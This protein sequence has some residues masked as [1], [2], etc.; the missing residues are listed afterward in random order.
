[1]ELKLTTKKILVIVI[2]ILVVYYGTF[3]VFTTPIEPVDYHQLS[4]ATIANEVKLIDFKDLLIS[5][6]FQDML[7]ESKGGC[8]RSFCYKIPFNVETQ[9]VLDINLVRKNNNIFVVNSKTYVE[10]ENNISIAPN[11]FLNESILE[12]VPEIYLNG[13]KLELNRKNGFYEVGTLSFSKEKH[14]NVFEIK[15]LVIKRNIYPIDEIKR[16]LFFNKDNYV[17]SINLP[18]MFPILIKNNGKTKEMV[19]NVEV[20]S[21]YRIDKETSGFQKVSYVGI[22]PE[23]VD[24]SPASIIINET[25]VKPFGII[26]FPVRT[27]T[28]EQDIDDESNKNLV[29]F[30]THISREN[31][32]YSFEVSFI[33]FIR[34]LVVIIFILIIPLLIE[35]QNKYTKKIKKKPEFIIASYSIILVFLGGYSIFNFSEVLNFFSKFIYFTSKLFLAILFSFPLIYFLISDIKLKKKITKRING[36]KIIL[37]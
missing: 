18:Q 27:G 36:L 9:Q 30:T 29:T 33:P 34:F 1:M 3:I 8:I 15:N 7:G 6:E 10:T 13:K 12:G 14:T 21:F 5:G 4:N 23:S 19:Y 2:I 24:G 11:N 28:L 32:F 25:Q 31:P 16:P 20:P 37:E 22:I 17:E 35:F 26:P